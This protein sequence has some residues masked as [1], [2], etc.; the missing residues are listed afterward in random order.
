MS[1]VESFRKEE[2]NGAWQVT[3]AK[4]VWSS[5]NHQA[6]EATSTK[7]KPSRKLQLHLAWISK[8]FVE[9]RPFV[10]R[11]RSRLRRVTSRNTALNQP[12]SI[13]LQWD[14]LKESSSICSRKRLATVWLV[15]HRSLKMWWSSFLRKA[16]WASRSF[17]RQPRIGPSN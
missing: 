7:G 17:A 10:G 6:P 11:A 16:G 9:K 4:N 8:A 5:F 1:K 13:S 12:E 2:R 14:H 3:T 15:K